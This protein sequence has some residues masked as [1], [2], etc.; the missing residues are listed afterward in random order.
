MNRTFEEIVNMPELAD[1]VE[2][3]VRIGESTF[4]GKIVGK[5]SSGLMP[6]Y[7]VLNFNNIFNKKIN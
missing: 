6:Y 2:V 4:D 5:G 1:G 7:I 3:V